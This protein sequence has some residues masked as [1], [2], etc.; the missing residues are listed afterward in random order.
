MIEFLQGVALYLCI[1]LVA[2]GLGGLAQLIVDST[3]AFIRNRKDTR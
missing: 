2:I 3:T 1:A